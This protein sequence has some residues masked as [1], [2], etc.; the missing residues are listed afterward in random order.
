[1]SGRHSSL[2]QHAQTLLER[3]PLHTV[4]LA[5][6][7]LGLDGHPGAV[8]KAVFAL[9]GRDDRFRVGADGVWSVN[10]GAAP[11][12]CPLGSLSYAVVDVET[13]GGTYERG[14]RITEV[15]IVAVTGGAITDEFETLVNPCRSLPAGVVRLTGISHEMVA[16]APTFDEI[17]CEVFRRIEGRIF[18]AHNVRFDWGWIS[19]QLGDALGDVPGVDKL[20]TISMARRLLPELQRRSLDALAEFFSIPVEPRHRACGDAL[21]TARI[22]LRLLDR[23]ESLGLGD[24]Y[25]LRRY[26][27]SRRRNPNQME[28]FKEADLSALGGPRIPAS[29]RRRG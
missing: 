4:E 7:V 26:R 2:L 1:M 23:A 22:L 29:R 15:A 3:H 10:S 27:P 19:A 9:L 6:R 18:V 25:A 11:H 16:R 21:A 14:H 12:G 20:C 28:L 8:S 17:A 5:K 24:L 13:T